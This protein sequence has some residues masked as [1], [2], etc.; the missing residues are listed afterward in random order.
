MTYE[1]WDEQE[2]MIGE[3]LARREEI[4]DLDP[5]RTATYLENGVP[6]CYM[7]HPDCYDIHTT[8]RLADE[9]DWESDREAD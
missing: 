3:E 4:V 1:D 6:H 9:A 8:E 7:G 5:H 2:A